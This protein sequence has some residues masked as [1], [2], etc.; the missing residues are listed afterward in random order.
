MP[1]AVEDPRYASLGLADDECFAA[2]HPGIGENP[3]GHGFGLVPAKHDPH[4]GFKAGCDGGGDLVG[5]RQEVEP[6]PARASVVHDAGC[7]G[8]AESVSLRIQDAHVESL[9]RGVGGDV[10]HA[11]DGEGEVVD[12]GPET[13]VAQRR[14][15]EDRVEAAGWVR[16]GDE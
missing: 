12:A 1:V 9:L 15:Y 14:I 5:R 11:E 13:I 2:A 8:D 6:G 4:P 3:A 7:L 10:G 16:A